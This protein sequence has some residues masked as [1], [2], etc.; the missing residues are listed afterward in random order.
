M[1]LIHEENVFVIMLNYFLNKHINLMSK[2]NV[3]IYLLILEVIL[4]SIN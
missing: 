1:T 2:L 3:C 4:Y